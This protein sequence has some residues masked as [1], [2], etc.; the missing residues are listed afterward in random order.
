MLGWEAAKIDPE[1][2]LR[3]IRVVFTFRFNQFYIIK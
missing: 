3:K 1:S 2:Q